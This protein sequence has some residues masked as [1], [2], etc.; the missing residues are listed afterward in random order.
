[1]QDGDCHGV[2]DA[3]AVLDS[4]RSAAVEAAAA[5]PAAATAV[6]AAGAPLAG[7]AAT[8]PGS[9]MP[10][11][12]RVT[13]SNDTTLRPPPLQRT[14]IPGVLPALWRPSGA[15]ASADSPAPSHALCAAPH[16]PEQAAKGPSKYR[17]LRSMLAGALLML[18]VV[19]AAG[20]ALAVILLRVVR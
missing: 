10:R 2:I 5:A 9:N 7:A 18:L 20:V 14:N 8:T 11:L 4:P 15:A 1:L 13:D 17:V 19:V 12:C 16:A 3:A 6:S